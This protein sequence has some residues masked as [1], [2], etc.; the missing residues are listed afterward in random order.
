[1]TD[2]QPIAATGTSSA[3]SA[4][5]TTRPSDRLSQA[6]NSDKLI[7]SPIGRPVPN[8]RL[9]GL[10]GSIFYFRLSN[11]TIK[12]ES[13]N[14]HSSY[15]TSLAA[16]TKSLVRTPQVLNNPPAAG[17]TKAFTAHPTNEAMKD[18]AA[19]PSTPNIPPAANMTATLAV[20]PPKSID[21]FRRLILH[22]LGTKDPNRAIKKS[23][24]RNAGTDGSSQAVKKPA[25]LAT[26]LSGTT[27][28]VI[29]STS[30][31]V[32]TPGLAIAASLS[33][34]ELDSLADSSKTPL[35]QMHHPFHQSTRLIPSSKSSICTLLTRIKSLNEPFSYQ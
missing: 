17:Q 12:T 1:M 25:P 32:N 13:I 20:R 27:P 11:T 4:S 34:S 22:D 24:E 14:L 21:T 7:M 18:P 35:L 29:T 33:S 28:A 10:P 26:H 15:A 2:D 23:G 9:Q 30:E 19:S 31:T 5:D 6:C 8:N 16:A 3:V